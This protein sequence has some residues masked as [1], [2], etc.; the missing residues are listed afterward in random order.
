M[1]NAYKAS[2][3]LSTIFPNGTN[4]ETPPGG[5]GSGGGGTQPGNDDATPGNSPTDP[6]KDI[7]IGFPKTSAN[8]AASVVWMATNTGVKSV[9]LCRGDE[10]A[11]TGDSAQVINVKFSWV[12]FPFSPRKFFRSKTK[13][14]MDKLDGIYTLLGMD[15]SGA[16]IVSRQITLT[17]K[18]AK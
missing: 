3:I 5:M 8:K 16:I 4:T 14:P 17:I 1:W 18:T 10:S 11:C 7:F 13:I 15:Q 9:T 6:G 12:D 2:S